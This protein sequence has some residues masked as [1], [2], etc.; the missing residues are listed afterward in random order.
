[1]AEAADFA[2]R[3]RAAFPYL[4]F[5]NAVLAQK[6]E[7]HDVLVLDNRYVFRFPRHADHPTGLALERAVLTALQGRCELAIPDYRYVAPDGAF[8]GYGMIAGEELTPARFAR[9]SRQTQERVLD[10]IAD[11]VSA[12]HGLTVREIEAAAG[13][14][15]DW[16]REGSPADYAADG[17]EGRL[18]PIAKAFPDLVPLI[19]AFYARFEHRPAGPERVLHGDISDDHL[20]LSPDGERLGGVIDFG[21]TELGDP[22]HDVCYLWSYGDWAIRRVL[23]RY[24]FKDEDADLLERSRW[25]YCRYRISRLGEAIDNGWTD[26]A[27]AGAAELPGLLAAL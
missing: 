10:Q 3:V 23:E 9:L 21:D 25:G 16:P 20:L 14:T 4:G 1:M 5:A 8:A 12:M 27:A 24:A 18:P 19:E 2:A 7:D 6:G 13:T 26:V 17:R 11:F 15:F 22:M